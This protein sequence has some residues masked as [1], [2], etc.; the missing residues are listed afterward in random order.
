MEKSPKIGNRCAARAYTMHESMGRQ[1]L[2]SE[3][4]ESEMFLVV[5]NGVEVHMCAHC[6]CLFALEIE[7]SK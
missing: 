6:G 4:H 7:D 5:M 1:K 2:S 3:N